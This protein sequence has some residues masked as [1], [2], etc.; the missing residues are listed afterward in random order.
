MLASANGDVNKAAYIYATTTLVPF[1][2]TH[3]C[4]APLESQ[5]VSAAKG[6]IRSVF[7]FVGGFFSRFLG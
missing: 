3:V 5:A 7:N 2:D 4:A 6:A 1:W